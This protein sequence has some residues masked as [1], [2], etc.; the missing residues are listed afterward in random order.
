MQGVPQT[1]LA[2]AYGRR[3][4][5]KHG[6][7]NESIFP[8]DVRDFTVNAKGSGHGNGGDAVVP[9]VPLGD[10]NDDA[11]TLVMKGVER[12][13]VWCLRRPRL[14]CV[15]EGRQHKGER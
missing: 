9:L 4:S 7:A 15:Q 1:K 3:S 2:S 12:A 8:D 13:Q 14:S 10:A 6:Q 5:G 11:N